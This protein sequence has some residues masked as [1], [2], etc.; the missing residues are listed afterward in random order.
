MNNKNRIPTELDHLWDGVPT[1]TKSYLPDGR[2][3]IV[4]Y[5]IGKYGPK[6]VKT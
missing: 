6:P 4:K 2:I 1:E 5:E 3:Q